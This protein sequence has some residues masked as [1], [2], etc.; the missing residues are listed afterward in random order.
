MA[1][2]KRPYPAEWE[3]G[4]PDWGGP[5]R[6]DHMGAYYS[7]RK[8]FTPKDDKIVDPYMVTRVCVHQ[9]FLT[10]SQTTNFRLFQTERACRRQFQV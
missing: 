1:G 5:S 2:Y 8:C 10:L 7:G 3:R 9:P 4:Y 6:D